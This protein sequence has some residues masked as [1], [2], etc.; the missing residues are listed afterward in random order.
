MAIASTEILTNFGYQAKE[1]RDNVIISSTPP[2]FLFAILGLITPFIMFLGFTVNADFL[3]LLIPILALPFIHDS[4]KF[5]SRINFD[6]NEKLLSLSRPLFL[7]IKLA[8]K[9]IKSVSVS[10]TSQSAGTSP[11][12]EGNREIIYRIYLELREGRPIRL[13]KI[14]SRKEIP[15]EINELTDLANR[16]LSP[17][18]LD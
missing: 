18:N 9:E 13:L 14:K 7:K 1:E 3:I 2:V 6:S 15:S 16:L 8:Y 17:N 5:P 11:F 12:E 10:M 4:W